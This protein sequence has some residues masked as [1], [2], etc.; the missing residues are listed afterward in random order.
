MRKLVILP[1]KGIF[2]LQGKSLSRHRVMAVPSSPHGKAR[3]SIG[4]PP[5]FWKNG[6]QKS[7]EFKRTM[8]Q[9]NL[10]VIGYCDW[11]AGQVL[12]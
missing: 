12:L 9:T 1:G 10:K 11:Q 6:I 8:N 4:L 7:C 5:H 2:S 3:H